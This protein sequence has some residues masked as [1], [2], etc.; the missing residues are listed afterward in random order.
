MYSSK[1]PSSNY[2]KTGDIEDFPGLDSLPKYQISREGGKIFLQ[3]DDVNELC[4]KRVKDMAARGENEQVFVI[5][6]TK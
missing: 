2:C 3:F 5:L 6:G 1:I 4:H